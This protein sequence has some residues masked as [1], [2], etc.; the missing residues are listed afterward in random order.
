MDFINNIKKE[1]LIIC[2]NS[3]KQKVLSLNKLINI[4]FMTMEEF[5]KKYCFDYDENTIL[6]VI[7][8]YKV[9]YEIAELYIKNIYYVENKKYNN[10]LDFLVKLKQEL[11]DNN[12]LIYNDNFKKYLK[13]IDIILYN[14]RLDNYLTRILK[15]LNYKII[16]RK[17]NNYLNK[18]Y[19]FNTI[20]EECEF[21]AY[22]ISKLID[23]KVDIN[24]IKLTNIDKSYYNTLEY[25]F[26]L[27]NLKINIPYK[28]PLG[29]Y[30]IT[31]EFINNYKK[32][33]LKQAIEKCNKTKFQYNE[34]ISI[35]N[36]YQKYN[37]DELIIKKLKTKPIYASE[38][39]NAIEIID[40]LDY[41][42]TDEYIFMLGFN[43]SLIPKSYKDTNYITDFLAPL[44]GL[45]T[46]IEK[47]N[48]LREDILNS[49]K[50]I[51]NLT[52][53]YK[54]KD[55][56]KTYYPSTLINNFEV[57]QG[58]IN[59]LISYSEK[60]N[61]IKLGY[62]YDNY[63]KYGIISEEMKT[64]NNNFKI[65][66]NS[67]SNKYTKINRKLDK[68][69]LSYSKMQLYNK[70]AFRYYLSDILK[71]DI[72]E[73]NFSTIIGK[74]VHYIMEQCLKNN[75]IDIDKYAKEFLKDKK[76]NNK[77][78][79]FLEKYKQAVK[80]LLE[81]VI[82]EKEYSLFN[83]AMYEKRIE[84]DYENNIKFVGIIDK[85]L[86]YIKDNKTYIA[87]VDYKTGKDNIS[88]KYLKEGIDI[89]LPIY[90]Y[91]SSKL[92]F[93]NPLYVGF[94]LQKL[95][96]KDKN[97]LLEGYSNKDKNI[98]KIIDK[99]YDNSCII[100]GLKTKKDG[101]FYKYSKVLSNEEI[102]AIKNITEEVILKTIEKIKNNEFP[103]N[104][105]V[106]KINIGCMYC[107]FKD[108][109]YMTNK[110][111]VELKEEDDG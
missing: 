111:K 11:I 29:S 104:P 65:K 44:V 102:E 59:N 24:K 23:N 95:D 68:L 79:F 22:Q 96:I 106:D 16:K 107:K 53:T 108:I 28:S 85:I 57:E 66:Y 93:N 74:M 103:I 34:I 101:D 21:V 15:D 73:E 48:Y 55:M 52:I 37:N 1:T 72:F 76:F 20:E 51:K 42:S 2:N 56:T 54:E 94:Y 43:D 3:F 63:L 18:V 31:K 5:N 40:Y 7:N 17:Y 33:G 91:L 98:L 19:S 26:N 69:T 14:I 50:D 12:L 45:N 9:T 32:Y 84:V 41:I 105:K 49:I 8:K 89:Q 36:K 71:L 64:L 46:T 30:Q 4:K 25:I 67:Y 87:L 58:N 82:K 39:E 78:N 88:L 35:I 70:C 81:E 10:K 92:N 83:Q 47:N 97:Y 90:L 80:E 13:T 100:K 60:M 6:Y 110:D 62:N 86:Y 77:E 61:K 99:N 38:Y 109:C 75:S 27:Y